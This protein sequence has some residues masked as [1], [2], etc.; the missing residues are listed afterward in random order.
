MKIV[1]NLFE[2]YLGFGSKTGILGN[3]HGGSH[4]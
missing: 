4:G 2:Q 3:I 1:G